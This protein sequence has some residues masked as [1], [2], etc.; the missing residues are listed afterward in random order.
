MYNLGLRSSR[1]SV[2]AG[3]LRSGSAI[4]F[5]HFIDHIDHALVDPHR[6]QF[7]K[8]AWKDGNEIYSPMMRMLGRMPTSHKVGAGI[9]IVGGAGYG[10]YEYLDG[11]E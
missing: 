10:V 11:D 2:L 5:P 7:M 3:S 8:R 9:I 4:H 1:S 6:Y